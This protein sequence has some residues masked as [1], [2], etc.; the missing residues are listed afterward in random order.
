MREI[1]QKG[2]YIYKDNSEPTVEGT[3]VYLDGKLIGGIQKLSLEMD[4]EKCI[5]VLKLEIAA[6]GGLVVDTAFG[7][8]SCQPP[9]PTVFRSTSSP[10]E[11]LKAQTQ[12][13][14]ENKNEIL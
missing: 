7:E 5:P 13:E 14:P 10:E 2:W 9:E 1:P 8:L 12:P 4:A 11:I 6:F 3:K